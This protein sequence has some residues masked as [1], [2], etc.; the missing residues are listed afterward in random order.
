MLKMGVAR[1]DGVYVLSSLLKHNQD[2]IMDI[3]DHCK[4]V[5]AAVKPFNRTFLVV[6]TPSSL[7]SP[8]YI[9]A[10]PLGNVALELNQ[11]GPRTGVPGETIRP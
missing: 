6:A 1:H 4:N 10:A 2:E 9:F 7:Q 3:G 5:I 11:T 8:G